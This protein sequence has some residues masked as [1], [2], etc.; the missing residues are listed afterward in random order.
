MITMNRALG[1]RNS[2]TALAT[3]ALGLT[4]S[5]CKKSADQTA[6]NNPPNPRTQTVPAENSPTSAPAGT[7]SLPAAARSNARPEEESCEGSHAKDGS[8]WFCFLS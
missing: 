4:P 6:A 3:L 1:K 8:H 7:Q 5:G 2:Y